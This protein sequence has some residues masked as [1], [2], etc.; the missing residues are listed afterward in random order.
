MGCCSAP[1][2]APLRS[3]PSTKK[4]TK[5]TDKCREN[6]CEETPLLCLSYENKM[7]YTLDRMDRPDLCIAQETYTKFESRFLKGV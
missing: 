3:T 5:S 6:F 4:W 1:P 7:K 2:T